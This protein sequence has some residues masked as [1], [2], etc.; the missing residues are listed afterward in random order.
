LQFITSTIMAFVAGPRSPYGLQPGRAVMALPHERGGVGLADSGLMIRGLQAKV[1]QLFLV[2]GP[3][4]WQAY[5]GQWLLRGDAWY[6]ARP[7]MVP[8]L[9][10]RLG[11]GSRLLVSTLPVRLLQRVPARVQGY[12]QAF[13]SLQPCPLAPVLALS[14]PQRM[15]E[16]LFFSAAVR[17]AA[18]QPIQP[19]GPL[20][21]LLEAGITTVGQLHAAAVSRPWPHAVALALACLPQEWAPPA[22]PGPVLGPSPC[23]PLDPAAW[24]FGPDVPLDQYTVRAAVRRAISRRLRGQLPGFTGILRPKLWPDASGA[25]GLQAMEQ[26]WQ[27]SR[28]RSRQE[29]GMD[30]EPAWM[31]PVRPRLSL[32]ERQEER[33]AQEQEAARQRA[34]T[35]R[36][37]WRHLVAPTAEDAVDTSVPWAT[38]YRR[39]RACRAPR[40][41]FD[42][43]WRLLHGALMCGGFRAY[44]MGG[45]GRA[46]PADVG[47]P[48][49]VGGDQPLETLSHLFLECPV[50]A[51]LMAW[52]A[53]LWALIAGASPPCTAAVLLLGDWQAWRP[54]QD[55][56]LLW[57]RLRLAALYVIWSRRCAA[58]RAGVPG[59]AAAAVAH[60]VFVVRR[61]IRADWLRCQLD[62][63]RA[64]D[65]GVP[66]FRGGKLRRLTVEGFRSMWCERD[67][68]CSVAVEQGNGGAGVVPR[69]VLRVR[70]SLVQPLL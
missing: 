70:P 17:D 27:P 19:T 35:A 29:A 69:M 9:I 40:E 24:G 53:G 32:Q 55:L 59:S 47:C 5:M 26:R 37:Q 28:R 38:V 30:Q 15:G 3:H 8:R 63:A 65:A 4:P 13:R 64:V 12:I 25:A 14:P 41:H 43:A 49:H 23:Q 66:W 20:L 36:Q 10:D 2:G 31:R 58:R 34:V 7:D 51:G 62:A 33:A 18:G 50:A 22:A 54:R 1:L 67:V 39:L 56:E 45:A 11:Y 46:A 68:L 48:H 21:P 61:Q 6:A 16:P 44:L 57:D 60:L 42:L 52:V